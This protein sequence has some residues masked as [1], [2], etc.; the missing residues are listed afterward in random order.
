MNSKNT[1]LYISLWVLIHDWWQIWHLLCPLQEGWLAFSWREALQT[2]AFVYFFITPR[3][4]FSL[5]DPNLQKKRLNLHDFLFLKS[6]LS[7]PRLGSSVSLLLK[8]NPSTYTTSSW[9]W[10][11]NCF[12]YFHFLFSFVVDALKLMS[13]EWSETPLSFWKWIKNCN[14]N[15]TPNKQTCKSNTKDNLQGKR[16]IVQ[17]GIQP[18][19]CTLHP[20]CMVPLVPI[21]YVG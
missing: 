4:E 6:S 8:E 11:W 19:Q 12:N 3:D 7:S 1:G 2:M 20:K 15:C 16:V 17:K 5:C 14:C 9:V 21:N 10:T 18:S 13:L